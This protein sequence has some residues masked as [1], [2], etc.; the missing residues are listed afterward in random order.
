MRASTAYD[1]SE[2]RLFIRQSK[3]T[4]V[5]PWNWRCPSGYPSPSRRADVVYFQSLFLEVGIPRQHI[6]GV[7][8]HLDL[9]SNV[10]IF[11]VVLLESFNGVGPADALTA[12]RFF[13]VPRGGF[14]FGASKADKMTSRSRGRGASPFDFFSSF[15]F[16]VAK[17]RAETVVGGP[18]DFTDDERRR[19]AGV[20]FRRV[21]VHAI[22][23][24]RCSLFE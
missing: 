19:L 23:M 17:K 12:C 1:T 11:L 9:A 10:V 2:N 5:E 3:S 8:L 18:Q 4:G 13:S 22:I 7:L 21:R 16:T 20:P 6:N 24:T 14:T 15:F